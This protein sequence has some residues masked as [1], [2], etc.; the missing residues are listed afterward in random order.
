MRAKWHIYD[1]TEGDINEPI[2]KLSNNINL[3]HGILFKKLKKHKE[4]SFTKIIF[5]I[6]NL[7]FNKYI[8]YPNKVYSKH[9][10]NHF[11]QKK[12]KLI[13]SNSPRNIFMY[14]NNLKN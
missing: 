5:K 3:W 8:V 4:N 11:P 7:F 6:T 13:V 12:F 2:T 9:L 1:C 10:L 14:E